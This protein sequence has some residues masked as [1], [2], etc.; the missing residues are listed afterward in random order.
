MLL[1]SF[2]FMPYFPLGMFACQHPQVNFEYLTVNSN[3]R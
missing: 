2:I 3:F 1:I